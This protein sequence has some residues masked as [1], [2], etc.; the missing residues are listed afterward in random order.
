MI[1]FIHHHPVVSLC[2]AIGSLS[3]LMSGALFALIVVDITR[4]LW[5]DRP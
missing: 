5:R 1:P 2:A 3:L 4:T